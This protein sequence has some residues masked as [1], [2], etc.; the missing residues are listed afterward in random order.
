MLEGMQASVGAVIASVTYE[1]K[2]GVMKEKDKLS[3]VI[4]VCAF[5]AACFSRST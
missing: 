4:L 5:A 3:L 1:M 2:A